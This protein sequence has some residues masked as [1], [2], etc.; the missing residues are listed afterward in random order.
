[1]DDLFPHGARIVGLDVEDR[2]GVADVVT[3][4]F[5]P[6]DDESFDVVLCT[7]AFYYAEDPPRALAELRRVLR[8]GGTAVITVPVVW[9]YDRETIEHR[10]TEPGLRRLFADWAEVRVVESGGWGVTW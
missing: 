8:P 1:Y 2:F 6:F 5:L 10:F 7:Q 3:R 4:E 9:E